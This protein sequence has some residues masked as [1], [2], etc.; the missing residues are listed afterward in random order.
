MNNDQSRLEQAVW[1]LKRATHLYEKYEAGREV[2]FNI[3]ST[4][5]GERD[6]VNLHSRFL[7]ALLNYQKS[8][9]APRQNLESFLRRIVKKDK[10]FAQSGIEVERERDNIDIL[11]TN[12]VRQAVVIE[13]KI[14]AEDQSQQ[15]QRYHDRL[16]ERGFDDISL[17]YLTLDGYEPSEDSVGNLDYQSIYYR[18]DLPPWLEGCQKRAYDEPALR[19]SI[20]QYLQLIRKLTGTDF[21]EAYMKDLEKLCLEGNNLT[22][23]HDL[24]EAAI[25]VRILLLKKLYG[26]IDS[27]LTELISKD[28]ADKDKEHEFSEETMGRYVRG[29]RGGMHKG[30]FYPF[31]SGDAQ[32]SVQFGSDIVFGVLYAKE[33]DEAKYS[34]LKEALKNVNGGKS[35][36]WWPWYRCADG[37]P[38]LRNPT[39]ENL[40]FVS[41][42]LSDEEARKKYVE[43]IAHRLKPVWDAG[44]DL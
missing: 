18:D 14:G 42:L 24:N 1:L 17:L 39:P 27:A 31:G 20:G 32:I 40:E 13:N 6:E 2:P 8:P 30:L 38:D 19:E 11:I 3:F 15:L 41:K 33:K 34:R 7:H 16:R 37:G 23:I 21:S 25:R 28:P 26:E 9:D 10:D 36:P 35:N 12:D 22:L 43:E 4:L 29:T 5:R 44:K